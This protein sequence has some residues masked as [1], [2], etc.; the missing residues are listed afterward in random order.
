MISEK[1]NI[2]SEITKVAVGFLR[3]L[4]RHMLSHLTKVMPIMKVIVRAEPRFTGRSREL[5]DSL[6]S[7]EE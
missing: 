1:G 6:C 5:L 7:L 2:I 4:K 3:E